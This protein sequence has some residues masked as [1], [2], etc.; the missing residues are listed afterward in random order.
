MELVHLPI[1]LKREGLELIKNIQ[2]YAAYAGDIYPLVFFRHLKLKLPELSGLLSKTLFLHW[3][4]IRLFLTS[5][6]SMH[7]EWYPWSQGSTRNLSPSTK[8]SRHMTHVSYGSP[9]LY[10]MIG[11]FFKADFGNRWRRLL[12]WSW[13][14]LY[15]TINS[16]TR[17]QIPT[18]MAKGKR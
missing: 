16:I 1:H 18:T 15:T 9:D 12:R 14:H 11:S 10:L 8:S 3:G 2:W 13:Q 17:K 4:H 5:H 7:L 6:G